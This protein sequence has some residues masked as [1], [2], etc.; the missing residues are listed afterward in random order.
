[1]SIERPAEP[2]PRSRYG[3]WAGLCGPQTAIQRAAWD[4]D[5]AFGRALDAKHEI[6][7]PVRDMV[8]DKLAALD[9][10]LAGLLTE[11]ETQDGAWCDLC[12]RWTDDPQHIANCT[13]TDRP[14]EHDIIRD[15]LATGAVMG[16]APLPSPKVRED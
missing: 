12:G 15:A 7:G 3:Y 4:L 14:D 5:V 8:A 13:P 9:K 2:Q 16:G 10:L 11:L 1:M 6:P